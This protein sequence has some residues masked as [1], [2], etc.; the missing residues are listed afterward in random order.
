MYFEESPC[1]FNRLARNVAV[2]CA[3]LMSSERVFGD[4]ATGDLRPICGFLINSLDITNFEGRRVENP[5]QF[6]VLGD[7]GLQSSLNEWID[8]PYPVDAT[9]SR[10]QVVRLSRHW[11]RTIEMFGNFVIVFGDGRKLE[12][13]FK[14]K[15]VK[16]QRILICE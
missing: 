15:Y 11:W 6:K 10:V 16:P 7:F 14:A 5:I 2:V 1:S 4:D 3:L 13:S 8:S 12:G 9:V